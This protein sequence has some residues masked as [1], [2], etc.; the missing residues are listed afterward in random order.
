MTMMA[1]P[2][3]AGTRSWANRVES[4]GGLTLQ[5]AGLR[6]WVRQARRKTVRPLDVAL[7]FR[8][9]SDRWHD[10]TDGLS[11]PSQI[12]SSQ[13]YL[14]IIALG[15]AVIPYILRDL[16]SR[17]GF[18]YPALLALA[19]EWPVPEEANGIPRLM[20]SAWLDWGRRRGYVN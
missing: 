12:A 5:S 3:T 18:W 2:P 15:S 1:P 19:G 20:K 17:G 14:D 11:S 4:T 13:S 10:E 7:A 6:F 8:A 9:L 16:E